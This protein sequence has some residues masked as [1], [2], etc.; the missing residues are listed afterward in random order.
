M[1][2]RFLYNGFQFL[3]GGSSIISTGVTSITSPN[4]TIVLNASTGNITEDVVNNNTNIFYINSVGGSD[5]SVQGSYLIPY[6]TNGHAMT[7]VSGNSSSNLFLLQTSGVTSETASFALKPYVTLSG[8]GYTSSALNMGSNS[9]TADSSIVNGFS[10]IQD[11]EL[12]GANSVNFD[13]SALGAGIFDLYVINCN[14]A[15]GFTFKGR[16]GANDTVH[17]LSCRYGVNCT[18]IDADVISNDN[19]IVANINYTS[20]AASLP[21]TWRANSDSALSSLGGTVTI[22]GGSENITYQA[23]NC[24]L[25]NIIV[26]NATANFSYDSAS[27]P[28]NALSQNSGGTATA[29]TTSNTIA[30][31]ISPINFTPTNSSVQGALAGIDNVLTILYAGNP[32]SN[33]AGLKKQFCLNTT[34]NSL[35]ICTTGGIAAS[36]IWTPITASIINQQ[37]GNYT[38]TSLD[39]FGGVSISSSSAQTLTVPS[40]SVLGLGSTEAISFPVIALGT[41]IIT[42][43]GSGSTI[44]SSIGGYRLF[45]QDSIAFL[46]HG[47]GA[48][49]W[50]LSGDIMV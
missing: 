10:V 13:L 36:A 4:G 21:L 1:S 45:S 41:G 5:S 20:S 37:T 43:V 8:N 19:L 44:A 3:S 30:N 22:T 29:L 23:T 25:F 33:V 17:F 32:N 47:I 6:S 39:L 49:L 31:N 26:D 35:Y 27:Y 46:T 42:V 2:F 38:L 11:L 50:I 14:L 15:G 28:L 24:H 9:I 48:N 12:L 16:A 40:D 34:N 18:V 7:Q